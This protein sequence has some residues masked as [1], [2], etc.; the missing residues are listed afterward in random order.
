[1]RPGL[2]ESIYETCLCYEL[3]K[4]GLHFQRQIYVPIK[5]DE[6]ILESALKLDVIVED[7]VIVELKAVD[8]MNPVYK[9]QLLSHMKLLE[10]RLGYLINFNVPLIKQGISR[11]IL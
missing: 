1:L 3:K 2:L 7:L 5:Y 6:I 8:E 10:K 11:L 4:A 9:S